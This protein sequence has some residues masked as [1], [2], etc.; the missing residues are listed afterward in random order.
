M[1]QPVTDIVNWAKPELEKG[2]YFVAGLLILLSILSKQKR[3][4][5]LGLFGFVILAGVAV[6]NPDSFIG[7]VIEWL[8]GLI[9][10]KS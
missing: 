5:L 4:G 10:P 6:L 7:K 1:F 8:A 2:F 9:T 3:A